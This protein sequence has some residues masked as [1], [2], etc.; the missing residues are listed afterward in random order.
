[1]LICGIFSFV[2]FVAFYVV[3]RCAFIDI[4]RPLA[5]STAPWPDDTP[6]WLRFP[7]DHRRG[8]GLTVGAIQ[9]STHF[10]T[11]LDAPRHF[12]AE[13]QTIDEFD[14][15]ICFG[16]AL[17]NDARGQERIMLADGLELP[18]RVLFRTDGWSDSMNFPERIPVLDPETVD[19]LAVAQVKLVGLDLPSVDQIDSQ[20]LPIHHRLY[21]G[22]IAILESL[23]LTHVIPG[24][25]QLSAFPLRLV[26]GDASPVRAVLMAAG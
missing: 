16:P 14:L 3:A 22:G 20:D 4:S 23:I 17:V 25:Y 6:F 11:H 21:K 12:L 2:A 10:A 15:A 9:A 24:R 18:P 26:G 13:G 19:R 5:E 1:L 7:F 8:D